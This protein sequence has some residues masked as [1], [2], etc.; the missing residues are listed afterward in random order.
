MAQK[1]YF[2][3]P[4]MFEHMRDLKDIDVPFDDPILPPVDKPRCRWK[5]NVY[6]VGGINQL[7]N[8]PVSAG[9]IFYTDMEFS[10]CSAG[11]MSCGLPGQINSWNPFFNGIRADFP[12][13]NGVARGVSTGTT[14]LIDYGFNPLNLTVDKPQILDGLGDPRFGAFAIDIDY[15]QDFLLVIEISVPT[16]NNIFPYGESVTFTIKH[17]AETCTS[18]YYATFLVDGSPNVV[19]WDRY[20]FLAGEEIE[21]EAG[22]YHI[23]PSCYEIP[24]V[25]ICEGYKTKSKG[26]LVKIPVELDPVVIKEG[27]C[28]KLPVFA[29]QTTKTEDWKNDFKLLPVQKRQTDND[30][31]VFKLVKCGEEIEL[32]DD[33]LGTFVDFDTL[34]NYPDYTYFILDWFKVLNNPNL[35]VGTYQFKVEQTISGSSIEIT[36][37]V[38]DLMIYEDYRADD[39]VRIEA[40]MNGFLEQFDID[41]SGL[42]LRDC[43]RFRGKFGEQQTEYEKVTFKYKDRKKNTTKIVDE[44]EFTLVS[45][46]IEVCLTDHLQDWIF[47]AD[48]LYISDFNIF[49][50]KNYKNFPVE[51]P[52][53]VDLTYFDGS[54]KA[55]MTAKFSDLFDNRRKLKCT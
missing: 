9:V 41:Y 36:S 6:Q 50:H 51:S 53:E 27:C 13:V 44:R 40:M 7:M 28:F 35:G 10:N 54:R 4:G 23:V 29:E 14:N 34:E 24:P 45:E 19:Y 55:T 39:T 11:M 5:L 1:T 32:N 18:E 38:Y 37:C 25:D 26:K 42:K 2:I 31:F 8:T 12:I 22:Q 17:T 16:T 52:S 3:L 46:D 30:T 15:D 20:G 43:V 48:E 49:N 21:N 33:T 47:K